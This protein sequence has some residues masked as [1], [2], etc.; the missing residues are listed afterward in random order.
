[1]G[2]KRIQSIHLKN[3]VIIL[4]RLWEKEE[5]KWKSKMKKIKEKNLRR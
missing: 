4:K 2:T 1:M 5:I 3:N